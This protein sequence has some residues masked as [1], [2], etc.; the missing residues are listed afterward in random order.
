M[1]ARIFIVLRLIIGVY[2]YTSVF[3][4]QN[5]RYVKL[6]V[7]HSTNRNVFADIWDNK[8]AITTVPLANRSDVAYYA[9]RS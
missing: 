7:V 3:E 9:K 2:C 4:R 8:R 1:A 5:N 6:P